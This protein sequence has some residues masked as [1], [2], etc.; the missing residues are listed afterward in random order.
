MI[1]QPYAIFLKRELTDFLKEK[2]IAISPFC[3]HKSHYA[4]ALILFFLKI[5]GVEVM[6][7]YFHPFIK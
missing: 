6:N 3:L 2:Y 5:Y 4:I 1:K 7:L